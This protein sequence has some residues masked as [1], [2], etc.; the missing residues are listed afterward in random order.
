MSELQISRRKLL[1]A[2][3]AGAVAASTV[4]APS[5]LMA[6]EAKAAQDTSKIRDFDMIK[7]FYANYPKKLAAVR[8]KLGRPLTLTEKLLF[9]HLYHPESLTEFKR[10]QDYIELRPDR[11][12]THDI[13]GPMAILQFLTS[14]KERIA[15]PAA[16]V[17]D[18]LVTAQTGVR[19]D[20]QIAD[21]DNVET[22][23]FLRDVSRR[24]GFDFW[25]AGTGICHQVFLENY[26]FPGAMMLVTDSHTPTAGGM[27][28][29]AIGVG[30]ADLVD[31][32]MGMEWEL[33]MPKIIGV[34]L[35]GKLSGW[36]SAK[37]VILKLSGILSTKGGT[38]SIIEFFGDGCQQLSCTGGQGH[39]L[40][41]GCR[42][43]CHHLRL[44][45]RLFDGSLS[46]RHGPRCCSRHGQG[47]C[48]R[49][50]R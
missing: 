49:S 19:K 38:N 14:G 42:S 17:A 44:P 46:E 12:G 29:L 8:A 39:D 50:A 13:G 3:A 16:L 32:L 1:K 5:L 4:S 33:K 6:K 7:A 31:A 28:M 24:Y 35:T 45:V 10:G 15:L 11:A 48:R 20:L 43:G 40:Q 22:Y 9:V 41:H 25:P 47:R 23:S 18:H 34:K 2:S 27:G 37:D 21:R 36:V 30:G 26:D